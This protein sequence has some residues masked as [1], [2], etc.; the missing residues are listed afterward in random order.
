MAPTDA[1]KSFRLQRRSSLT[2]VLLVLM[3][4]AAWPPLGA[5]AHEPGGYY[6][7]RWNQSQSTYYLGAGVPQVQRVRDSIRFGA[8]QWN[9]LSG[10]PSFIDG[11]YRHRLR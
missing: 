2:L 5:A 9:A 10:G 4:Y 11:G 1:V 3:M 7:G 8:I 6:V